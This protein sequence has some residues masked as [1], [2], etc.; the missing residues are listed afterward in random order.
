MECN[1]QQLIIMEL[2]SG[3][4]ITPFYVS[5]AEGGDAHSEQ[6]VDNRNN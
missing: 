1:E 3:R 6:V 5:V 2:A 4:T